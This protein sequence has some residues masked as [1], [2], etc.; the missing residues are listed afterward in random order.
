L[1]IGFTSLLAYSYDYKLWGASYVINGDCS[2]DC[3]DYFREYLIAHGKKKFYATLQDPESCVAWIK[4]D[5]E[6]EWEG[7]R[8]SAG[9]AY[10]QKTGM[11]IPETY[12]PKFELKGKQ[13][14]EKMIYKQYPKLAKKF[15]TLR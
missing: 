8:Y 1:I 14:D 11:D 13:F 12:K 4:S 15:S 7:I 3:F 5:D 2:D 10:K 9:E 6:D